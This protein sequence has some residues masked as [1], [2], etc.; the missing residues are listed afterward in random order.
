MINRVN[1][2]DVISNDSF[3]KL[4]KI[5]KEKGSK[6][7]YRICSS[8]ED[9]S[10]A[11]RELKVQGYNSKVEKLGNNI[12]VYK[13]IPE[14][15][16]LNKAEQ[17]NNFK[18][19]AWGRYCFQKNNSING[20]EEYN[21]DDGSIWRVITDENGKEYLVK[22]VDDDNEDKVLRKKTASLSKIAAYT[23]DN[24][25]NSIIKVIYNTDIDSQFLSD[26]VSSS[27]KQN[28]FSLLDEKINV[29]ITE[30]TQQKNIVDTTV[31]DNLKEYISTNIANNTITDLN[32]FNNI[33]NS[34][35]DEILKAMEI[36]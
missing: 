5:I 32:T 28:I 4:A 22:D 30:A 27:L 13:I 26:L 1:D 31:I 15:I 11:I 25:M 29:L 8:N 10:V 21:F 17:T 19:L 36:L 7:L 16:E 6:K 20:F 34:R 33:L 9:A 23:D 2:I 24:T 14:M 12:N 18:K 3:E 35:V